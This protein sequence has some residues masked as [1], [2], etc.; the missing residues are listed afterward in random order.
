VVV[1]AEL[2]GYVWL[3]VNGILVRGR[4]CAYE[5]SRCDKRVVKQ[6]EQ[7][8]STDVPQQLN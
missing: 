7:R 3:L 4:P 6:S 5:A 1:C 8:C 2:K